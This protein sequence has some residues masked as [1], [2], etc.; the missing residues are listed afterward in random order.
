MSRVL[1]SMLNQLAEAMNTN[2]GNVALIVGAP[3]LLAGLAML[4]CYF[5]ARRST[6]I[7]P[8]QALRE[9]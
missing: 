9:E 2:V 4:A 1:S 7:D 6:K 8:L 3:I 5:P